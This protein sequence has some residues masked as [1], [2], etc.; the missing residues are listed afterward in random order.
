MLTLAAWLLHRLQR[1]YVL[2]K[3][4]ERAAERE[5]IARM[6]HDSFM[7]ST[8]ALFMLFER[9]RDALAPDDPA[10]PLLD[11]TLTAAR[12]AQDE[13]RDT[14]TALRGA[15][16]LDDDLATALQPV[17]RLLAQQY[18]VAFQLRTTGAHQ[19]LRRDVALEASLI[20]REA[21]QNA[22][23]HAG[24]TCVCVD[25]HD[26]TKALVVRVSDNGHGFET[27]A[28]RSGHWGVAG[29]RERA[30]LI[31]A[32][33]HIESVPGRGTAVTLKLGE[34]SRRQRAGC[35][36]FQSSVRWM[37]RAIDGWS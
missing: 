28:R 24:A 29:M 8:H 18:G 36:A 11:A 26:G 25:I 10:R 15:D 16:G 14:L 5:R 9:A 31:D 1:Q 17:G 13:G 12:Q 30:A 19:L 4:R 20:A 23:R 2:L 22:F 6:L 32:R 3:L 37:R 35:C 7:Q 21:L 27:A 34:T 33:L